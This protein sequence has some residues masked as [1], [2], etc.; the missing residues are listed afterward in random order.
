MWRQSV[1]WLLMAVMLGMV[2]LARADTSVISR[3]DQAS[4]YETSAVRVEQVPQQQAAQKAQLQV[5]QVQAQAVDL[6]PPPIVE[7]K[8]PQPGPV[9]DPG[10]I[11]QVA[12]YLK[13]D[14]KEIK[15]VL[16]GP[17]PSVFVDNSHLMRMNRV[18]DE[19]VTSL[20]VETVSAETFEGYVT[21]AVL[22]GPPNPRYGPPTIELK[23]VTPPVKPNVQPPVEGLP[24]PGP[25]TDPVFI[26]KVA[27][28]LKKDSTEIQSV[29]AGPSV[30]LD[31]SYLNKVLMRMTPIPDEWVASLEVKTASGETF[32]G[33]VEVTVPD[34]KGWPNPEWGF[35][36]TIT[37]E[38]KQVEPVLQGPKQP[39]IEPVEQKV[40]PVKPN[41]QP[42]VQLPVKNPLPPVMVPLPEV[43]TVPVVVFIGKYS[44]KAEPEPVKPSV[45]PVEQKVQPVKPSVQPQLPLR[46]RVGSRR[47]I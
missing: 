33:Y 7:N 6:L 11:K 24:Q 19:W 30:F 35:T 8:L 42:P 34:T 5:M 36:P 23:Q 4:A 10:F 1:A 12:D 15:S 26:Q 31:N 17:G 13:R 44:P 39:K 29:V 25:V 37:I 22:N 20:K 43:K 38:L 9:T 45:Q 41:V 46:K 27:D 32:K 18:P 3:R 16:A 21:V 2:S 28:Y 47:F 14:P 40:E